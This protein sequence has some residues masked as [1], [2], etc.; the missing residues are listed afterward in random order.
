M[1]ACTERRE[2]NIVRI[3]K[4]QKRRSESIDLHGDV[5]KASCLG[6]QATQKG[7]AWGCGA[8]TR[9]RL[10]RDCNRSYLRNLIHAGPKLAFHH[11]LGRLPAQQPTQ[12]LASEPAL[13]RVVYLNSYRCIEQSNDLVPAYHLAYLPMNLPSNRENLKLKYPGDVVLTAY[14]QRRSWTTS[15]WRN[16]Q[17]SPCSAVGRG[18]EPWRADNG[19]LPLHIPQLGPKRLT[20]L[21]V[22]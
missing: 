11:P 19:D 16:P 18:T 2:I 12:I 6:H 21:T 1:I 8:S 14:G 4:V 9:L 10:G 17:M 22:E 20:C 13:I 3:S 7:R 5:A 15:T